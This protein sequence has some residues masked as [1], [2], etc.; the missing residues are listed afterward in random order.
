MEKTGSRKQRGVPYSSKENPSGKRK[1]TMKSKIPLSGLRWPL[2]L[3]KPCQAGQWAHG[4]G[5][6]TASTPT[7]S[8]MQ[9]ITPWVH[10]WD[11]APV[12]IVPDGSGG[13]FVLTTCVEGCPTVV[14]HTV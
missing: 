13:A 10:R 3:P 7:V 6:L 12:R 9:N 14:D 4:D 2:P 11:D 8:S 1:L 5:V